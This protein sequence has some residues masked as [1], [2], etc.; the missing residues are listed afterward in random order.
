MPG[1]VLNASTKEVRLDYIID[2]NWENYRSL[3]AF[4]SNI[5]GTINPVSTDEATGILPSQYVPLRVYLLGPYKQKIIQFVFT[6]TWIKVFDE[7]SLD[8]NSPEEVKHSVT[9]VFEQ[10]FIEDL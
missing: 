4:M 9:L 6:N 8:V 3:Y 7:I 1:K 10:Y 2:T 5:N